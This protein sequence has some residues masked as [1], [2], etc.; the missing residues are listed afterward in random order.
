[1]HDFA[2][3]VIA[4]EAQGS[5]SSATNAPVIFSVIAKLRPMLTNLLG[6]VGFSALL[7]RALA[8]VSKNIRWLAKVQINSDGSLHG[9]DELAEQIEPDEFF[10]GQVVLLAQ[11]LGLLVA[12][13]GE[14]LTL[15]LVREA[16]PKLSLNNFDFSK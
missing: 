1:M 2:K 12:F 9:L 3:R 5:K 15:N 11:L 7:S 16:W 13:I 14:R 10:E 8:L 6:S 4:H